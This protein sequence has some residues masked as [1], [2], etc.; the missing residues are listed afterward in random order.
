MERDHKMHISFSNEMNFKIG[1][2]NFRFTLKE[3]KEK[4]RNMDVLYDKIREQ[5]RKKEEQYIKVVEMNQQLETTLRT[6][7]MELKIVKKNLNQVNLSFVKMS[8]FSFSF[9]VCVSNGWAALWVDRA[10]PLKKKKFNYGLNSVLF[11]ISFRCR[12]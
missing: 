4:R 7:E 6:L 11:C 8:Y 3:E 1:I 10:L 12:A 9:C 5:L 2:F